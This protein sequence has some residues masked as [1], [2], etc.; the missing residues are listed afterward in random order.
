M[1]DKKFL[2]AVVELG[3][4]LIVLYVRDPDSRA[5]FY[6]NACK[7]SMWTAERFGRL[8]MAAELKYRNEVSP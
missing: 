3:T 2:T 7:A 1:S 4:A 5:R 8:A 6:L